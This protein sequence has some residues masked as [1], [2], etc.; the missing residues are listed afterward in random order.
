MPP[1]LV[2]DAAAEGIE[3]LPGVG[4]LEPECDCGAWD[5]CGHTTA[6]CHQVARL[7]DQDPFVLLLMRGRAERPLLHA[8]QERG[9]AQEGAEPAGL[10]A[11]HET[12]ARRRGVLRRSGRSRRFRRHAHALQSRPGP[13]MSRPPHES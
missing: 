3:L 8:L 5:H 7:L 1:H 9:S 13:L 11:A 12:A 4:D 2:E 10:D 6:L